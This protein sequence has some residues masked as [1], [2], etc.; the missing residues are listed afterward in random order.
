MP[1]I[2][3]DIIRRYVHSNTAMAVPNINQECNMLCSHPPKNTL[4]CY[5]H[6]SILYQNEW[7]KILVFSKWCNSSIVPVICVF[8]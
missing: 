1:W 5:K 8:L 6:K 4:T 2:C 7:T 3:I